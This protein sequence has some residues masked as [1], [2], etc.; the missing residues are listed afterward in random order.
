MRAAQLA[1]SSAAAA[2]AIVLGQECIEWRA[3]M[4][5]ALDLLMQTTF[6][7]RSSSD[8][9]NRSLQCEGT[10]RISGIMADANEGLDEDCPEPR[11]G[12]ETGAWLTRKNH[13]LEQQRAHCGLVS[14]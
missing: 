9:S 7:K 3:V 5:R 1:A 6:T 14:S 4:A 12:R 2:I 8:A 10:G 11:A 13:T